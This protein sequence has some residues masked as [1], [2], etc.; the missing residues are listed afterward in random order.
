MAHTILIVDDEPNIVISLEY[1][2]QREG[3]QVSVARDGAQEAGRPLEQQ[4]APISGLAVRRD[5]T[6]MRQAIQRGD[7]RL[8]HPVGSGIVE[9]C[10]QSKTAGITLMSLTHQTP[11]G[12]AR[13]TRIVHMAGRSPYRF[14][15]HSTPCHAAEDR[16]AN[17]NIRKTIG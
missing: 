15:V 17:R 7:G 2:M 10:N 14:I 13:I 1:L 3:F 16:M 8:H 6:T 5:R 11:I 9:A 12:S 4:A